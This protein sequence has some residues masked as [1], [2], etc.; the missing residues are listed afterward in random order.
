M[1]R[2]AALDYVQDSGVVQRKDQGIVGSLALPQEEGASSAP[3]DDLVNDPMEKGGG[4]TAGFGDVLLVPQVPLPSRTAD[5]R[6][7]ERVV[8]GADRVRGDARERVPL[9]LDAADR[10]RDRLKSGVI[11]VGAPDPK[12]E[13]VSIVVMVTPD[14]ASRLSAS[15]IVKGIAGLIEGTGGG[16]PEMAQAGGKRIEKLDAALEQA[17]QVIEKMLAG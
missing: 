16:K 13:K 8:A 7:G 2:D 5:D 6:D 3:A 9:H 4:L 1:R 17:V 12:G 10:L 11:I 15:E 14:W